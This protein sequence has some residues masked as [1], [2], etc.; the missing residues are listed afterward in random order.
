M[1]HT[2]V[3]FAQFQEMTMDPLSAVLIATNLVL[4]GVCIG[5]DCKKRD[6]DDKE[7]K[8]SKEDKDEDEDNGAGGDGFAS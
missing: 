5:K 1:I 8:R 7:D 4:I 6:K 3:A 2:K